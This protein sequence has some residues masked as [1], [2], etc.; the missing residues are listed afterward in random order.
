[1]DCTSGLPDVEPRVWAASVFEVVQVPGTAAATR[2]LARAQYQAVIFECDY[3]DQRCLNAIHALKQ[4][5]PRLPM[6]MLVLDHSEVLAVWAFRTRLWNYLTKPVAKA[7]LLES[8]Q[9][10][11][12]FSRRNSPPRAGQQLKAPLPKNLPDAPVPPE[13]ARLM[14]AVRYVAAHYH[15]R[16][17]AS[18]AAKACGLT[19]FEFSRRFRDAFGLTFREYLMRARIAE[20]RRLLTEGRVSITGIAYSVGFN[21]GS[22][23]ARMFRRFTGLLPSEYAEAQAR[24][25]RTPSAPATDLGLRRRASDSSAAW[26]G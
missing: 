4:A 6:I 22:H 25:L 7:E 14:P 19:R 10:V 3:P 23:F 20:A 16:V 24:E 1:V 26:V 11:A 18:S 21:D 12:N 2:E 9:T 15:Q 8:L 13:V 17:A 5:H